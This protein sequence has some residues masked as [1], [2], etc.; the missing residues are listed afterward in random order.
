MIIDLAQ[1]TKKSN[2]CWRRTM[3]YP[4]GRKGCL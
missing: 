1:S 2:S 4:K 3:G